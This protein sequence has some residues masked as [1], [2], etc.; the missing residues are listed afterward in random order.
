MCDRKKQVWKPEIAISDKN[1]WICFSLL[2]SP[3]KKKQ[4]GRGQNL[5]EKGATSGMGGGA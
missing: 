5:K 3:L 1:D 2:P 4:L